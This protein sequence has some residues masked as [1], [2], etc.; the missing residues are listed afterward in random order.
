MYFDPETY[1]AATGIT[2]VDGKAYLFDENGVEIL[3]SRT[4]VI[5]GK[6]YW[7]QPDGTLMSGWCMLGEWI[8]YYDPETYVGATGETVINGVGYLFDENGVLINY[9][10]YSSYEEH[11]WYYLLDESGTNMDTLYVWD[12][13]GLYGHT[14]RVVVKTELEGW[15]IE[16]EMDEDGIAYAEYDDDGYGNS[17]VI[18]LVFK[19]YAIVIAVEETYHN[20]NAQYGAAEL[21]GRVYYSDAVILR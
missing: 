10:R 19:P 7:F 5:N 12:V 20:P 9:T 13:P 4:E 1:Q 18:V 6:K 15:E 14:G 2:H 11:E 17:G 8:M 21:D 16:A 3:K